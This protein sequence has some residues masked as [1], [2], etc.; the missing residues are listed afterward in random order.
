V[1]ATE[2]RKTAECTLSDHKRN[3]DIMGQLRVPQ[4][5]VFTERYRKCG[6]NMA[7]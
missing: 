1:I 2:I 4:V 7:E 5:A 6:K 3:A